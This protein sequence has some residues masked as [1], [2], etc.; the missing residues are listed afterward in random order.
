MDL[1]G[2]HWKVAA[3][4]VTATAIKIAPPTVTVVFVIVQFITFLV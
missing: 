2:N 4:S 1:L 3:G